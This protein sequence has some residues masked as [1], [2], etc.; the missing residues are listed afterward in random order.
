MDEERISF[1]ESEKNGNLERSF[2]DGEVL[3]V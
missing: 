2:L 1:F 3:A